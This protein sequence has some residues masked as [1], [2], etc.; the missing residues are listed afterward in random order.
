MLAIYAIDPSGVTRGQLEPVECEAVIRC[1]LP[2]TFS[3]KVADNGLLPRRLGPGWE[4]AI[5]SPGIQLSGPID[6]FLREISAASSSLTLAGKTHLGLLAER[7]IY[8]DPSAEAGKQS[9]ARYEASGP[10]EDVIKQL[11]SLNL[12]PQALPSRIHPDFKLSPSAG[13]GRPVKAS[14]RFS[15]LLGAAK[16]LADQGGLVM[17]AYRLERGPGVEFST[18]PALDLS[19][20]VRLQASGEITLS[21]PKAT[22]AIMA[23]QGEGESRRVIEVSKGG[24]LWGRRIESFFDRRDTDDISQLH[25]AGEQEINEK[26]DSNSAKFTLREDYFKFGRDFQIGDIITL[27]L[28]GA[29]VVEQ[30]KEVKI[31]WNPGGRNVEI[32]V[33]KDAVNDAYWSDT[34]AELDRRIQ[35]IERV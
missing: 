28:P 35:R 18:R 16:A 22:T 32:S 34:V 27:E 17:D 9:K 20:R 21:A 19:R 14:E 13:L 29:E 15:I 23:G 4:L 8:P 26:W 1:N 33:G 11:V 12:G 5:T 30:V 6:T 25:E 31:T 7:V 2:G 24:S 3:V 10:A